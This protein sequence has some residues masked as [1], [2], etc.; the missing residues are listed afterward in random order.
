M[1]WGR[2]RKAPTKA[3]ASGDASFGTD[4]NGEFTGNKATDDILNDN[5]DIYEDGVNIGLRETG[6]VYHDGRRGSISTIADG[7]HVIRLFG[8]DLMEAE[9][10]TAPLVAFAE[11]MGP[12][13]GMTPDEY[14]KERLA[15]IVGEDV[16][17]QAMGEAAQGLN[18]N[19]IGAKADQSLDIDEV[20]FVKAID[21]FVDPNGPGHHKPLKVMH[22]PQVLQLLGAESHDLIIKPSKLRELMRK[23]PEMTPNVV[24]QIPRAMADPIMI[25]DSATQAGRLVVMLDLKGDNGQTVMVPIQLDAK[26]GRYDV[27][28]ITSAFGNRA[29]WFLNQVR[30][31]NL[32]YEDKKKSRRWRNLHGLQLPPG[33]PSN[34][35]GYKILTQDDLVKAREAN[36]ELYAPEKRGSIST[37]A[38]GRHVIKLF[39]ADLMEAEAETA[40]L[41]A[42][43]EKMGPV[44]GMTPDEYIKERLAGIVG[45][46]VG[47]QAMGEAA[48]GLGQDVDGITYNQDGQIVTDNE[49]FKQWFGDSKVVGEDGK[50]L[51][52]YRGSRNED[53][54]A[55]PGGMIY[56][57]N[58]PDTA[59]RF[60]GG[61]IFPLYVRAEKTIDASR[62]E[63][64]ALWRQFVAETNAPSYY[65]SASER[66]TLP[67][68]TAAKAFTDWLD[69]KG[70]DYDGVYFAEN[71]R[72]ASLAVKDKTQ[73]KSVF[74][75]G[76]FDPN[77]HRILYQAPMG[78]LI[79]LGETQLEGLEGPGLIAA[80]KE[81]AN[82]LPTPVQVSATATARATREMPGPPMPLSSFFQASCT[83]SVR[84]T[85]SPAS[86]PTL[87]CQFQP[88]IQ[89]IRSL[90]YSKATAL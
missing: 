9:A 66:G 38:D 75:R 80:A 57:T 13:V 54:D 87:L 62:G 5:I 8:A 73:I 60:G 71:D 61:R 22:T 20:S 17:V 18:Q 1:T 42:F 36:Q 45:E 77:D 52:L 24:K 21:S 67:F 48:Q 56:L 28:V 64:R 68:W 29:S 63:G 2:I 14:I 70:V 81:Y 86:L 30:D 27:N 58:K 51:V 15:G 6:H 79:E 26:E 85:A 31:G 47:V 44:V 76:T 41:V 88:I 78:H 7:R 32:R 59:A 90:T 11:N 23:H 25:F 65:S 40:P 3:G 50:P 4:Q 74:N 55:Y 49:N 43:A 33:V 69:A 84:G 46:D 37:F 82:V 12:V 35:S 34:D 10:E 89:P 16:G 83:V 19:G 53:A 72:S 39:G